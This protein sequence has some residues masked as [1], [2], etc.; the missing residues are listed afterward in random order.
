MK[1]KNIILLFTLALPLFSCSESQKR[2]SFS[3]STTAKST[4]LKEAF[5][6][7]PMDIKKKGDILYA[8]DFKGDSL[9]YCYSLSEQRFV[10]QMLPQGQGP[11][12]FLSPVE[13]F[14]SVRLLSY[15]IDGTSQRKTIH[16]TRKTFPTGDK[17]N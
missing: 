11:D 14:L 2:V 16:S 4:A 1:S 15:T 3:E 9:L 13:F 10:N 12:E 17:E 6:S 7:I 5:I 8:G